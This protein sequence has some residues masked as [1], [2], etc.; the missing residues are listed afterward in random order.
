MPPQAVPS[1]IGH[2]YR[3]GR[4]PDPLAWVPWPY[5]GDGRFD[6]PHRRFR[7]L[8]AGERRACF[9]EVLALFRPTLAGVTSATLT[10]QW[11]ATRRIARFSLDDPVGRGRWLDLR[12]AAT[13]QALR[14]TFAPQLLRL[15]IADFDLSAATS[16][17]LDLTQAIAAWAYDEGYHGI[18]AYVTRFDPAGTG[19]A[20]FERADHV[21]IGD[22]EVQP[23]ALDDP[24]LRAVA[25]LFALPLPSTI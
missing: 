16:G 5:V 11:L 14:R 13:L 10:G 22:V 20:I 21:P 12:S 23:I 19:W 15:G 6:D 17:D 9:L 8:Y 24:D 4:A 1:P 2:L 7:V 3:I 18:A 25:D